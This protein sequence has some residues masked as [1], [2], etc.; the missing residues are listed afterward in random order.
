VLVHVADW[1]AKA[2]LSARVALIVDGNRSFVALLFGFPR[3][4]SCT[5][6][7]WGRHLAFLQ[8]KL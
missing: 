5:I 6:Y 7:E 4:I 3:T 8:H 2:L 1:W